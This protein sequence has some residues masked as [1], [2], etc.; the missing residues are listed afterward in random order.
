MDVHQLRSF[1]TIVE[2]GNFQDAANDLNYS[3]SA[4]SYQIQQLENE[5]KFPLFEKIGR[6][7]FPTEQS[8]KLIPHIKK[9][10]EELEQIK[11]LNS[12][13][14]KIEGSIN[15]SVSDSLL[16]YIIQPVLKEFL[17]RAP[18]VQMKL[19]VKN[20]YETQKDIIKN[21][22]DLGI[23]FQVNGYD[24]QIQV[25][26]LA[27]FDVGLMASPDFAKKERNFDLKNQVKHCQVINNDPN[28]VY[29]GY[30]EDYLKDKNIK[31]GQSIE[32][33][34][35]EAVKKS[36]MNNLGIA[37]LPHFVVKEEL[38]SKKID[39]IPIKTFKPKITMI[40][41]HHTHKWISPAM[42]LFLEILKVRMK[43]YACP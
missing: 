12:S 5:L 18:G 1:K 16:T 22:I 7:M 10:E 19:K 32:L 36:V 9:I 37:C 33:W 8:L 21:N 29:Q 35:I 39:E 28:G 17:E 14:N 34:S 38:F 25:I 30:F 31:V 23:H 24:S 11:L 40:A 26:P 2:K 15:I 43:E 27:Q 13:S 41:A 42:L 4:I 6:R 3:L 20:C